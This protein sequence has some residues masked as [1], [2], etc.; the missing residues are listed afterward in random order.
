MRLY[1]AADCE[2]I[3]RPLASRHGF[4][5]AGWCPDLTSLDD[6]YILFLDDRGLSL[7]QTG[8]GAAGPVR[9]DFAAGGARHRRLYGG[10]K[11]QAIARAVGIR[12][13]VRPAVADLTAGLGGDAFVLA[14][15]GC[16]VRLVER[17]PVVVALLEDGLRRAGAATPEGQALAA[18]IARMHLIRDDAGRWLKSL[19]ADD[20]PD[21]IYL[22][23]MF[24]ERKKSALVKKEM[25]AFQQVVGDDPD[26]DQLL[27]LALARARHRV[28]V[29]R[30]AH[31]PWLN[32]R[33]PGYS[34]KG[35]SVRFDIYPL[36]AMSA[37]L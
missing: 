19:S 10:G 15:L 29:K 25:R 13:K 28:V 12:G 20:C 36:K 9:C 31:A 11:S 16:N 35:K 2:E 27:P 23:P 22:D 4:E 32:H 30:P 6:G 21:V 8:R 14:T 7:C 26:A 24:P 37:G 33:E 5:P 3:A 34:L 1:W 18:A 17:H